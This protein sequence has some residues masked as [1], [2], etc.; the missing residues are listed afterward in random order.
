MKIKGCIALLSAMTLLLLTSCKEAP[1]ELKKENEVLNNTSAVDKDDIELEYTSMEEIRATAVEENKNNTTNIQAGYVRVSEGDS[2][3]SYTIK[4]HN[5]NYTDIADL[6]EYC[7][8]EN[9]DEHPECIVNYSHTG[10]FPATECKGSYCYLPDKDD[11]MSC[12]MCSD[13]GGVSAVYYRNEYCYPDDYP[14]VKEYKLFMGDDPGDDSYVMTDGK[15]LKVSDAISSVETLFNDH[16]SPVAG[17]EFTYKV[18]ELFVHQY[19]DGSYGYAYD[20]EYSDK[21]GN[22]I[23]TC[24]K[25]YLDFKEFD[26][27][28]NPYVY[29]NDCHGYVIDSD[30][31][32]YAYQELTPLKD[33]ET[34]SGEKLLTYKSAIDQ[35]S[36]SLAISKVYNV[37][38]ASL[39]YAVIYN[40]E[41]GLMEKDQF[42]EP[43]G[44]GTLSIAHDSK[45][46]PEV[47]PF[48]V[49][50]N[51]EYN[52][53]SSAHSGGCIM[54]DAL[55][56]NVYVH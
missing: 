52:T 1:E 5:E 10:D 13:C 37:D 15:E 56:G 31:S 12:V 22:I 32:V 26:E 41:P 51:F 6:V 27:G 55:N 53:T 17:G 30:M 18:K 39:E 45:R 23:A 40:A 25:N 49:F 16:I 20:M 7:Y 33:T 3:P 29:E 28:I 4:K 48:W 35:I 47:R 21:S 2:M 14:T 43:T 46:S 9:I 36:S 11:V 38:I 34:D 19:D 54:V 50:R 42:G 8:G 44:L 24:L